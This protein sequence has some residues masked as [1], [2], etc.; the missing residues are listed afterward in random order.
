MTKGSGFPIFIADST[1]TARRQ[2]DPE[3]VPVGEFEV[4]GREQLLNV[5][6]LASEAPAETTA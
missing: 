4:R 6:S 1:R 3:L 2:G 5:W